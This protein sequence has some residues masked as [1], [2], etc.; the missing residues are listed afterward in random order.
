MLVIVKMCM[1]ANTNGRSARLTR[2]YLSDFSASLP[3]VLKQIRLHGDVNF[4][5]LWQLIKMHHGRGFTCE[6]ETQTQGYLDSKVGFT[7][8]CEQRRSVFKSAWKA[9]L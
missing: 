5:W 2:T 8:L 9:D 1:A 6:A 7:D 4:K 3:A